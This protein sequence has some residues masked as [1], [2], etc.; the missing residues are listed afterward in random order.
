M[1]ALAQAQRFVVGTI[2]TDGRSDE[3][4]HILQ[5]AAPVK[6]GSYPVTGD[7]IARQHAERLVV[8]TP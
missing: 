4:E 8:P 2:V 3:V 1:G 6:T 5:G 7:E